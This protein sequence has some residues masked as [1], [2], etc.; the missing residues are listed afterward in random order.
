MALEQPLDRGRMRGLQ[1]SGYTFFRLLPSR[2]KVL[3]T[4]EAERE[5]K[6]E[7]WHIRAEMTTFPLP[8]HRQHD[9]SQERGRT[10]Q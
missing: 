5:E 8:S 4:E 9:P 3:V 2:E 1:S 10:C 6:R 7:D